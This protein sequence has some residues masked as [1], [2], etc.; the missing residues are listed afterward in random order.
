MCAQAKP[1]EIFFS[2]PVIFFLGFVRP[3]QHAEYE[4]AAVLC[5]YKPVRSYFFLLS[6]DYQKEIRRFPCSILFSCVFFLLPIRR[7]H[8]ITWIFWVSS[9]PEIQSL[10][11]KFHHTFSLSNITIIFNQ[12]LLNFSLISKL[13]QWY[14]PFP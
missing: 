10:L 14:S 2:F 9:R 4:G 13:P 7:G 12:I 5:I 6:A 8:L 11:L 1:Q 3:T